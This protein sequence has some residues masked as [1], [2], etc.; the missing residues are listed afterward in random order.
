MLHSAEPS[1]GYRCSPVLNALCQYVHHDAAQCRMH[2]VG[3]ARDKCGTA[4][5]RR[6]DGVQDWTRCTASVPRPVDWTRYQ[7][8]SFGTGS[9]ATSA[10]VRGDWVHSQAKFAV[11]T[12]LRKPLCP[13]LSGSGRGK[14]LRYF[15]EGA[16]TFASLPL[17]CLLFM[18]AAPTISRTPTKPQWGHLKTR[19]RG[20]CRL[21]HT[22]HVWLVNFSF[23]L[24]KTAI[25]SAS[26]L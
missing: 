22:G 10:A 2:C 17:T 26:A 21:P 16:A 4:Q 12:R 11:S 18:L 24:S 5:P 19:P 7:P 20:V 23:T 6:L 25:P 3:I 13:V 15:G 1:R 8:S 9:H 14:G